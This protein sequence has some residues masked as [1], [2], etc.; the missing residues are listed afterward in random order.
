MDVMNGVG[1]FGTVL[2]WQRCC[3]RLKGDV[4]AVLHRHRPAWA[5]V[6]LRT[7]QVISLANLE[8]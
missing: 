6:E 1:T 2:I 4:F 5:D 8:G 3:G 7:C